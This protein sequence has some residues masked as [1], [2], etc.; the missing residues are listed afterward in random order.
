MSSVFLAPHADDETLFGAFTLL[1]EQPLVVVV[2]DDGT[3]ERHRE[4]HDAMDTLGIHE[5]LWLGLPEAAPKWERVRDLLRE[6]A[7]ER[8]YAPLPEAR[9]NDH[10]NRVGNIALSVAPDITTLYTTY[11]PAGRTEGHLVDFE[12]EWIE[13]KLRALA[14]YRSQLSHPSHAPHFL[15]AQYE[16]YA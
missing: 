5:H 8:I 3:R 16:F 2:T 12:H 10:H 1:R 15:R 4:F 9:G 11:T 13:A 7:P 14:C 6:L